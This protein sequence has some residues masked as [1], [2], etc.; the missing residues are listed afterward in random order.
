MPLRAVLDTNILV[1]AFL[2]NGNPRRVLNLIREKELR[3]VTSR[4]LLSEL[5]ETLNK[6]VK[7]EQFAIEKFCRLVE[8]SSKVVLPKKTLS[9]IDRDP[10][11]NRILE[12]AV[13][14]K[15]P[16][17]V[18]GDKDLLD[19]KEYKNIRIL[20]ARKFLSELSPKK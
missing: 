10:D 16:Y 6:K 5:S 17:I 3:A 9:I 15:C 8:N 4:V 19:L 12:A 1:S 13:E 2:S 18:T 11:D 20:S 7:D 14:G